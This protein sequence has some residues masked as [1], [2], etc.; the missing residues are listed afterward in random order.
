MTAKKAI[1]LSAT[2]LAMII[3][4]V[5]LAATNAGASYPTGNS[6]GKGTVANQTHANIDWKADEAKARSGQ[7]IVRQAVRAGVSRPLRE[8]QP[9]VTQGVQPEDNENPIARRRD[10]GRPQPP[11]FVD[12]ARQSIIGPL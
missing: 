1:Q 6:A 5:G 9:K 4:A 10:P 12:A 7:P 11:N 2:L 3:L 8:M